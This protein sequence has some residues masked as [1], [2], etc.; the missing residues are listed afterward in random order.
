MFVLVYFYNW[1]FMFF[2][3]ANLKLSEERRM[4]E[5]ITDEKPINLRLD[6][7]L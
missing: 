1:D 7:N 5:E 6:L 4:P 3:G 2:L